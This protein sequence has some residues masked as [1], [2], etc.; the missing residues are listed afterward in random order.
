MVND[1]SKVGAEGVLLTGRDEHA[2]SVMRSLAC[3]VEWSL[4]SI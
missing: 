2:I 3:F 1:S 4:G